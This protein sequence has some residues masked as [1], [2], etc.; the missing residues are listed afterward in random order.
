MSSAPITS[1]RLRKAKSEAVYDPAI[2]HELGHG[3][4]PA[5]NNRFLPGDDLARSVYCVLGIPLD[6]IDMEDALRM[7]AAA[8]ETKIPLLLS[9][10]NLNFIGNSLLD[11]SFRD[12]L[13][14]SDLC[15]ADGMPV[16]WIARLLGLPIRTRVAGSDIFAELK[17][18]TFL[19]RH[20]S[21]F[22]FGG[23]G[24]VAE[25]ACRIL[26]ASS[27]SLTCAGC[28]NPGHDS[29]ET[30]S[31][32][33]TVEAINASHA[34]IL[35]V[36]LGAA[37]GQAWLLQ[38]HKRIKIP[39]RSHLGAVVNFQAGTAQRAPKAVRELGF[40]WLWR[41][42]EEPHLWKRYWN[43]GLLLL[44]LLMG[45]VMPLALW[46]RCH[47]FMRRG[48]SNGLGVALS[49]N[50]HSAT[51]DLRGNAVTQEI[52]LA[53]AHFRKALDEA[54]TLVIIDLSAV[55]YIDARFIGLI[56]M[57]RKCVR[58]RGAELRIIG[59]TRSLRRLFHLHAVSYLLA[60]E[61]RV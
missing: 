37:K 43:D 4:G 32:D 7:I 8:S 61:Q 42:K 60:T 33:T 29:V 3:R 16:I 49:L 19:K 55:R 17:A 40:E 48:S 35:C 30:M 52:A 18:G 38:N 21:V 47:Q 23:A 15:T 44:R 25:I 1:A 59:A 27:S 51:L 28:L 13:L 53:T 12:S 31:T 2:E 24:N 54:R 57:M 11:K 58:E 6:A 9:T 46:A 56:M 36:S 10:P 39:V 26:N 22:F 45:R 14:A 5:Q 50:D 20:F 34:D 41:I